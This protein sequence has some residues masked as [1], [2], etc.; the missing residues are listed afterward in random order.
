[1]LVLPSFDV[2][3][4]PLEHDRSG[5]VVFLLH[6]ILGNRNNWRTFARR[7]ADT[8]S[9]AR[10]SVVAMDH[11][12]HGDNVAPPDADL[13]GDTIEACADELALLADHLGVRPSVT[14]GHSFG[15]KVVLSHAARH[16]DGLEQV[17]VL[18]CPPGPGSAAE[19]AGV[20]HEVVRMIEA[21]RSVPL[22]LA[23]R[24]QVVHT[25]LDRGMPHPM[26]LWMTTN[27]KPVPGGYGFRFDLDGAQRLIQSYFCWDGWPVAL[28][29]RVTPKIEFVRA[30]RSDRWDEETIARLSAVQ[31]GVP[32]RLHLLPDAG[33]W[34]HA[35]NPSGLLAMLDAGIVRRAQLDG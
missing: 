16:P 34:L 9:S 23:R 7:L 2:Y 20:G 21:L 10:G 29:A 15:G 1:M 13:A 27:L 14:I 25:L 17:W 5:P 22:P 11:R 28:S 31:E 3:G 19:V 18:D 30:E 33:H 24:E 8:L 32:T 6:G 35:D 4:T 12:H 26:A